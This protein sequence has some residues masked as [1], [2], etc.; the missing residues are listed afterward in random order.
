VPGRRRV[1]PGVR[2][3][4]E[5]LDLLL[6]RSGPWGVGELVDVIGSPAG[7]AEALDTFQ[8]V[9]LIH[10]RDAFVYLVVA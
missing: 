3:E 1:Q 10:R 7:V 4:W 8:E 6:E 2:V 5:I 9:G